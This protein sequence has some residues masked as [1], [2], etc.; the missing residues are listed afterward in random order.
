MIYLYKSSSWTATIMNRTLHIVPIT[1]AAFLLSFSS[2]SCWADS[3]S[4]Q[5]EMGGAI[6]AKELALS[7]AVTTLAGLSL[8]GFKDGTGSD[9]RFNDPSGITTDGTNLYVADTF[10]STIRKIVISTGAVTTIA[11]KAGSSGSTDGTGA[12]ARFSHSSGITTD[13]TNLYVADTLNSTIRKIVISTGAVTTIAGKAVS[14]GSTDGTGAD[15]RF[16]HPSGIT[17]DGTNLYIADTWENTI[18]KIVISTGVVTT[19]AGEAHSPGSTD[20]TGSDAR[21]HHPSG[22]TTDGT[23]LYVADAWANTI[24]KI[25]IST[26]A[27]TTIAGKAGSSGSMDGTGTDARFHYPFGITTDGTNLYVTD[28]LDGTIRKIVISTGA[29]TTIAGK[30]AS[31][32]STDGTGADARFDHPS[33]ITTDGNSLLVSDTNNNSVRRIK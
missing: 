33:G 3:T 23:N 21:F 22:I 13:G 1:F 2:G 14:W 16:N 32:G 31:W 24:R 10:N 25:V 9:S 15:S 7:N 28:L 6:Q 5:Y 27:V 17:T 8:I 29:V 18:R 26:G 11:G 19:I 4:N 30:A 20:G 12:D